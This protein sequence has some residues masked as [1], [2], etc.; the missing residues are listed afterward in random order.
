M[1]GLYSI[2]LLHFHVKEDKVQYFAGLNAKCC[3]FLTPG[4]LKKTQKTL[5]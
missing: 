2:A 3:K 1:C 4:K 5:Q